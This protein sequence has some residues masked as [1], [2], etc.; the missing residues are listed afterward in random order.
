MKKRRPEERMTDG[1]RVDDQR[2]GMREG[3][4][5]KAGRETDRGEESQ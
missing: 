2:E 4:E 3:D 1:K 5:E